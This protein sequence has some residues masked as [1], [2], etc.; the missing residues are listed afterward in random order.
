MPALLKYYL[1]FKTTQFL[2][3]YF[4]KEEYV[5][6]N[7]P[8]KSC[9]TGDIVLLEVLPKMTTRLITHQVKEIIFPLGDV[10]D[11]LTQQ[12]VVA[13]KFRDHVEAVNKVYGKYDTAY[14]YKSA[15]DRGRL[16]DIKDFTHVET[17]IKYHEF[18]DDKQPYAV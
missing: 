7:D 2:F 5:Y 17:Y 3:Q 8:N 9:K 16:E 1:Q 14:N 11:P 10:T 6:A 12:K 13:G 18:E 4:K 15:P